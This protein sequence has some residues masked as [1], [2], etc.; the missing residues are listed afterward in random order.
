MD[1]YQTLALET[2]ASAKTYEDFIDRTEF[3]RDVFGFVV[4]ASRLE[5]YKKTLAYGKNL[6]RFASINPISTQNTQVL[7]AKL[8][9]AG[10][11][12]EIFDANSKEEVKLECGDLL[13]YM[14][15]LLDAYGLTFDEVMEANIEKLRNR[16][17]S[18]KFTQKEALNR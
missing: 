4:S 12:G 10:E 17:K 1:N 8:G 16:Y 18:G 13:W 9:I 11:S 3:E 5:N 6:P 2:L 7:H 15:V 14:A